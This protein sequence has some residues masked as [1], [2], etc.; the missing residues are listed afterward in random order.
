MV[1]PRV[2]D[3]RRLLQVGVRLGQLAKIKQVP[4]QH[5]MGRHKELW[6]PR[7]PGQAE[8]LLRYLVRRLVL[9]SYTIETHKQKQH[10]KEMWR[11]P[12]LS[13]QLSRPGVSAS[14]FRRRIPVDSTQRNTQADL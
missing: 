4:A 10:R 9:C 7:A 12:H 5:C 14:Y 2:I 13:T 8:Q 1:L 6:I 3:G 11:F